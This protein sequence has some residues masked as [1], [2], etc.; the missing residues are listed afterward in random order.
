VWASEVGVIDLEKIVK[1][2][3]FLERAS[4]EEKKAELMRRLR[5]NE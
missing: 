1:E 4:E 5:A 3:Y 2:V